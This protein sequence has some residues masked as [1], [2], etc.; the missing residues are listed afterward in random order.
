[1]GN[2]LGLDSSSFWLGSVEQSWQGC[3]RILFD[4]ST[5]AAC[6]IFRDGSSSEHVNLLSGCNSLAW[7]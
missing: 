5:T 7:K 4:L 2:W 1:M 3:F 6:R